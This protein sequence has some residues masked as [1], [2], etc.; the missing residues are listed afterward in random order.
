MN[1]SEYVGM[2]TN[3]E[4]NFYGSFFGS[5]TA[6]RMYRIIGNET[7]TEPLLVT[8]FWQIY[9][10]DDAFIHA[11]RSNL[12]EFGKEP[13]LEP[14]IVSHGIGQYSLLFL[15]EG[16]HA[17]ENEPMM[18]NAR[19]G[20][21]DSYRK[22]FRLWKEDR[23]R[24]LLSARESE[25]RPYVPGV[26]S[27]ESTSSGQSHQKLQMIVDSVDE[28][29]VIEVLSHLDLKIII[30]QA[31]EKRFTKC[32]YASPNHSVSLGALAPPVSS[33]GIYTYNKKG[34]FGVTLA[35]HSFD[36]PVV[37][38]EVYINGRKARIASE[39]FLSDSC[40]AVFDD[41]QPLV[42]GYEV[43]GPLSDKSPRQYDQVWFEGIKSGYRNTVITGWSPDIPFVASFSQLKVFT[44]RVTDVGD[45]GAALYD[46]DNNII[47][48]SFYR[49]E[50]G[51]P[52]EFSAWIW[53]DSVFKAHRLSS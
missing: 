47:G 33:A 35:M 46:S 48:F 31:P 13:R 51:S 53:A 6:D 12:I 21:P 45:S 32:S 19:Q 1:L 49:T 39:D 23:Q 26:S 8:L 38:K 9:M 4:G 42:T 20:T 52:A 41:Q 2:F 36:A 40:F 18:I 7:K 29:Y 11:L 16:D 44:N 10:Y 34:E 25:K 27:G 37:N 22:A 3:T 24:K 5:K 14:V 30:N 50:D 43:N 28:N 17:G 15:V